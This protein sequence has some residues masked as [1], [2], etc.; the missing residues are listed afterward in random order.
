MRRLSGKTAI[1]TGASRGIGPYIARALANEKM[2]LVVA[3][4]SLEP[5]EAV[6]A[7][8]RSLGVR[9][10]AVQ[11][12]VLE[13]AARR[14]LV[15]DAAREFGRI[16]VLV[17]NAGIEL[18]AHF[19]M[20]PEEEIANVIEVNLTAAMLLARATLPAMLERKS[21]HIVNIASL[22]GKVPVPFSSPYAA[23]KAGL[24]GFTESF[25]TEFR[26]RGV[27]ASVVCPGFVSEAGM[28][29]DMQERA[30]VRA[31]FLAGTVSPEKVARNVV[32]AI[33][34]DRPEMLVYRGP[35]RM[36]TGLAELTPGVFERVFPLFRTNDL[37]HDL[38]E[39]RARKEAKAAAQ[40]EE[41]AGVE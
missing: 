23:S 17:N 9:A 38:A 35:G 22:A 8:V 26:K 34:R 16:D 11:C 39:A 25:R 3:A 29:A 33:K 10:V 4:R 7:E 31:N 24:I 27:S 40:A 6:A 15:A 32:T 18:T 5:L 37:F 19:E 36:I 1:I 12:D 2:N 41:P 28:Y 13:A 20:Q 14:R 21:G 30:G